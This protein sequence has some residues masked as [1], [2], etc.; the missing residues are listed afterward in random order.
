MAHTKSYIGSKK[1]YKVTFSIPLEM[2]PEA[3]EIKVMGE[4]NDWNYDEAITLKK[5]KS[6]YAAQVNLSPGKYEYRYLID[7]ATWENDWNADAYVPSPF[8]GIDNCVLDLTSPPQPKKKKTKAKD[9]TVIEGIG[10]KINQLIIDAGITTFDALSNTKPAILKSI[11]ADA[12]SRYQMHD[13]GSWPKQSK[14]A[15]K[16]DWAGLEK[17]KAKLHR[18]K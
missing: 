13:P 11:L 8:P 16:E 6:A 4:F 5:K 17:L 2:A 15:A 3:T 14:L 12:G 10:P 9:F 18:G 7:A 1:E